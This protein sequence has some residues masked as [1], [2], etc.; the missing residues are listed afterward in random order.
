LLAALAGAGLA[1][2]ATRHERAAPNLARA[3]FR[4]RPPARVARPVRPTGEPVPI[5][6]YH[7]LATVPAGA[8]FPSLFVPP[9]A[10]GAQ[11]DWLAAH[12]YHAVTLTRL[13]AGWRGTR[14]LPAKPVVL[15]FDDGY[16]SDYSV[17][18]PALLRHGWPGVLDLAVKNL[19][20]GD[21]ERW[22]VRRLLD[23]GWEIAAHTISHVDLT[24]VGPAQLRREV[25]GSRVALQR[26]FGVP[27]VF[28]CYPLGHFDARV[29]A[30]VRAAGYLGATTEKPGLAR[31]DE[32]YTLARIRVGPGEG[33][34]GV[35][36]QLG[37]LGA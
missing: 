36:A 4:P 24:T 20:P 19:S 18:L 27:V 16:L 8:R 14:P 35:A 15:T 33:A 7:V 31:P 6:M 21:I 25:A 13:L 26:M 1:V 23:A 22:Q 17:A 3:T 9:A 34:A 2:L 10:L 5:L 37:R 32:R 29:V 12:G 30:A 11:V 28:F